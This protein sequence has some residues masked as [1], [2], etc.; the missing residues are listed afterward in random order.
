[1]FAF[2]V[3]FSVFLPYTRKITDQHSFY[4]N[5]SLLWIP[6]PQGT[7][8]FFCLTFKVVHHITLPHWSLQPYLSLA[9]LTFSI[10]QTGLIHTTASA[11]MAVLSTAAFSL[12]PQ[13]AE[14]S[15]NTITLGARACCGQNV[16]VL[17]IFM[18]WHPSPQC[19]DIRRWSLWEVI[20]SWECSLHDWD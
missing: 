12:C 18:C 15:P 16:C 9:G 6:G 11:H 5:S 19:D 20:K 2:L 8:R 17:P 1:M 4:Q 14:G 3:Y 7:L 10:C 13:M